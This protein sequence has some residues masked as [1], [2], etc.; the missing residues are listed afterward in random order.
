MGESRF[1]SLGGVSYCSSEVEHFLG[2]EEVMGSNPISSS[3][4][5]NLFL[6][7]KGDFY[8]KGEVRENEAAR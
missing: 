4:R 6:V 3:F 2:K 8:G 7:L 1:R 5:V